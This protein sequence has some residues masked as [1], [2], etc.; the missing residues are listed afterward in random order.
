MKILVTGASGF[1]GGA[2][3][4]SL[5]TAGHQVLGTGRRSPGWLAL[6]GSR[7]QY[8]DLFSAA[9][10]WQP[11]V[12]VHCAGLAEDR[13]N[14]AA[15]IRANRDGTVAVRNAYPAAKFVHLSSS[16]VYP[17]KDSASFCTGSSC[18]RR[19][20]DRCVCNLKGGR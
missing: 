5:A 1:I 8:W 15:A 20:F 16:S 10:D 3:A 18:P 6:S 4:T 12:V 13:V 17:S 11:D 19:G 14:L 2:I 7:Y 9:P